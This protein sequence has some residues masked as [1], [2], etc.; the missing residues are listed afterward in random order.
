MWQFGLLKISILFQKYDMYKHSDTV[1]ILWSKYVN[2]DWAFKM[3]PVNIHITICCKYVTNFLCIF[4][5]TLS[6]GKIVEAIPGETIQRTGSVYKFTKWIC[7]WIIWELYQNFSCVKQ[8]KRFAAGRDQIFTAVWSTV[9]VSKN[10]HLFWLHHWNY[11][12]SVLFEV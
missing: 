11:I 9:A 1:K 8:M 10:L 7:R 4:T 2:S 5:L 12:I 3:A 6:F